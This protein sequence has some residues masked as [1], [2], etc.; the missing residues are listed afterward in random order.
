MNLKDFEKPIPFYLNGQSEF[1][2]IPDS[3]EGVFV[4]YNENGEV[5]NVGMSEGGGLNNRLTKHV[6]TAEQATEQPRVCIRETIDVNK[7][8]HY[9]AFKIVENKSERREL[10]NSLREEY[11]PI[12][13]QK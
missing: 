13:W 1:D 3:E 7:L 6:N 12:C 8:K 4:I 2:F 10:R 11:Q 9:V 5:I